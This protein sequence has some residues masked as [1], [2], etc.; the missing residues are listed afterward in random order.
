MNFLEKENGQQSKSKV[1]LSKSEPVKP[2]T[3]SATRSPVPCGEHQFVGP[4]HK[5]SHASI[6]CLTRAA[7]AEEEVYSLT[8][9]VDFIRDQAEESVF[10]RTWLKMTFSSKH[11][12]KM[13]SLLRL[14]A[15]IISSVNVRPKRAS[16]ST[17]SRK[18]PTKLHV[19][20]RADEKLLFVFVVDEKYFF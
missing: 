4:A 1:N 5:P 3:R 16:R 2:S 20:L 9:F 13:G 14:R 15:K 17:S 6:V 19:V 8:A 7:G 10:V 18:L 12:P 11:G